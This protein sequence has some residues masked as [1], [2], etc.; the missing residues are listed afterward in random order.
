MDENDRT[1]LRVRMRAARAALDPRTRLAAA[2]AVAS[3]LRA[4]LPLLHAD[5]RVAGYW[6]TDGELGLHPLLLGQPPFRYHLPVLEP[7]KR[8]RFVGW[9][10]GEP[11]VQNRFGIPEPSA[12]ERLSGESLDLVLLPLLAFDRQGHRLGTGGGYYDRS[13]A[14]LAGVERPARPLLVGVGYAL[15]EV[16][17]LAPAEWDIDLDAVVT[18]AG[19]RWCGRRPR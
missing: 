11:L 9:R 15:Q 2:D 13:F 10:G 7:G 3:A 14:F 19:L 17:A 8:L 16:D 1:A 18:E 5:A 4:A 6:A 12:G